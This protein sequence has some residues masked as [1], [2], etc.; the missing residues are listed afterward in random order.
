L[1]DVGDALGL[2]EALQWVVILGLDRRDFSFDS[3]VIVD[4]FNGD[5]NTNNDF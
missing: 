2:C 3:K 4:A 1:I 5:N